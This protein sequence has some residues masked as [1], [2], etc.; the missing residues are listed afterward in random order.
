MTKKELR[1]EYESIE[2]RIESAANDG[3]WELADWL[4][5]HVPARVGRP[6]N[7]AAGGT[8][9]LAEVASWRDRSERHLKRLRTIALYT[10]EDRIPGVTV[11][12]YEEAKKGRA[13]AEANALL[14][15]GSNTRLLRP[16]KGDGISTLKQ[17]PAAERAAIAAEL[18]SDRETQVEARRL[19]PSKKE[20]IARSTGVSPEWGEKARQ[21]REQTQRERKQRHS[22]RYLQADTLITRVNR[23]L[24]EMLD[25]VRDVPFDA[26]ERDLLAHDIDKARALLGLVETAALGKVSVDW[27][28]ELTKLEG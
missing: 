2:D 12:A 11:S 14:R 27:D 21:A 23:D 24:R 22:L 25:E 15:K 3:I 20:G 17:R 7:D 28:A 26:E 13:L 4:A 8:V 9:S 19:P 6:R 5:D 16:S 1:A 18:L 10:R